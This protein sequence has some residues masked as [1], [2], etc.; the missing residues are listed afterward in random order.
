[1]AL[2]QQPDP[3]IQLLNLPPEIRNK[4]YSLVLHDADEETLCPF[5]WQLSPDKRKYGYSLTQICHQIRQETLLMWHAGQKLLFAM[6]PENMSYY[7][8][9]LKRRPDKV[10]PS[11]RRIQL[12]DYQHCIARSS[13]LHSSSCRSAITINLNK[14]SPVSWKRDRRCYDCPARD[15]AADR[16]NAVTRTLKQDHGVWVLTREKMEEIFAAAAWEL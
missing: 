10:L 12:E 2:T 5:V 7:Q 15:P 6:R 8:A 4:I 16:V 14:S 11:I 9:W 13:H 1:M 3:R